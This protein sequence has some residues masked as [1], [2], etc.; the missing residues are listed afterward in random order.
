ME[1]GE[2]IIKGKGIGKERG[3]RIRTFD[4]GGETGKGHWKREGKRKQKRELEKDIGK[5]RGN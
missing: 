5:G 2:E 3:N 4:R 1:K